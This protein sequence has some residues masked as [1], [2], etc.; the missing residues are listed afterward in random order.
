MDDKHIRQ[1]EETR[2]SADAAKRELEQLQNEKRKQL[3]LT[4]TGVAH[5]L[6]NCFYWNCSGTLLT[7]H[8][9]MKLKELDEECASILRTHKTS[10][11]TKLEVR[12]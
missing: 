6:T 11:P 4:F 3:L 8:E 1:L 2:G 10:I 12:F 5:Y 9:E 7:Q